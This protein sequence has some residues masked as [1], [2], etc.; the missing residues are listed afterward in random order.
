MQVLIGL[1]VRRVR[2][3]FQLAGG[4]RHVVGLSGEA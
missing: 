2:D 4:G 3:V 1:W